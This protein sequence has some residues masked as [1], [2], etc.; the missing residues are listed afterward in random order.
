V[1]Y[2]EIDGWAIDSGKKSVAGGV[3]LVTA[4]KEYAAEYGVERPDVAEARGPQYR[5]S[6]FR[7]RLPT[8][9]IGKGEHVMTVK[10]I[11]KDSQACYVDSRRRIAFKII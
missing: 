7:L 10:V 8:S 11:S 2:V 4:A 9:E 3:L 6:G 1:K 5:F